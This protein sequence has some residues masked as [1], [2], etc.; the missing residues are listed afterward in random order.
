MYNV[1][2]SALE[3]ACY[4]ADLDPERAIR[5]HYSGRAMYGKECLGIVHSTTGELLRFALALN[6]EDPESREWL[7]QGTR[8]DSMGLDEITYWPQVQVTGEVYERS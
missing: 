1:S 3:E 5:A 4:S 2:M 7:E 6:E 8:N